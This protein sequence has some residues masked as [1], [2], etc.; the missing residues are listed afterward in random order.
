MTE[1]FTRGRES[2]DVKLKGKVSWV[3]MVEP[4]KFDKWSLTLHPDA[5]SMERIRVLQAEGIKNIVKMD[6]DG[7]YLQ[8]SRPTT[9][10]LR[11][12]VKTP[13]TPPTVSNTD[14][15][16]ME[17]IAIGNGSDAVVTVE[18][19]THP[20]PNTDRRAKAMRLNHLEVLD[21][22]PFAKIVVDPEP[23]REWSTVP[24]E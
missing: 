12:G 5:P 22:I 8:I 20:V 13:V 21:L 24:Q 17:G 2:E 7:F 1:Y 6:D 11:K 18:V 9:V 4:N 10:E 14:G 19:Y 16:S 23:K 3:R 15:S